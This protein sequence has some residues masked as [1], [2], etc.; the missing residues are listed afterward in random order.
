MEPAPMAAGAAP[1]GCTAGGRGWGAG[2]AAGA[3]C[4]PVGGAAGG[5][6]FRLESWR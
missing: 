4:Q 2:D 3:E 1:G 6:A 5:L